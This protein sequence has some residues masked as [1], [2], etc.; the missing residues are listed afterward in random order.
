MIH[1]IY[2]LWTFCLETVV[3]SGGQGIGK[4]AYQGHKVGKL[5]PTGCL[6][7]NGKFSMAREMLFKTVIGRSLA[8]GV[9]RMPMENNELGSLKIQH[10]IDW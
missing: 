4:D 8:L 10:L 3:V 7:Q 9:L 1:Y 2:V 6:W 5:W